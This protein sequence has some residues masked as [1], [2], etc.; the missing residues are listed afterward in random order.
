VIAKCENGRY[1]RVL[2]AFLALA[3]TFTCVSCA[4]PSIIGKDRSKVPTAAK[5]TPPWLWDS[6]PQGSTIVFVAAGP[7]RG[8][9]EDEAQV[10]LENASVQ[11]GVY[12]GFWGASQELVVSNSGGANLDSRTRARY[13]GPAADA[14]RET[15]DADAMWRDSAATWVRFTLYSPGVEIPVWVPSFRGENPDW[16]NRPPEIPGFHVTVGL[17]VER[18]TLA[19]TIRGADVSALADMVD[20]L[21]GATRTVTQSREVGSETFYE[22]S[23]ST[24]S[25]DR[26]F[27]E[28]IGF[29]IIARWMDDEGNA[30]ALAVC[31]ESFN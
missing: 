1:L 20:K 29:L 22:S 4:T 31:P 30:W 10:A 19:E 24:S 11:A 15:M 16:I 28:V 18:S 21:H 13:N 2:V 3:I 17:G 23:G 6:R 25:Y 27:G 9:R 5:D 12:S 8:N 26:G 7:R 14:A